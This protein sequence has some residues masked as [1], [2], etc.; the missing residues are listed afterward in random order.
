MIYE[1][2]FEPVEVITIFQNGLMQPLRFRWKGNVYK[3]SKIH[4]HWTTPQGQA[5]EHH[6]AVSAGSPDSFELV[7]NN[8]DLNWQLARVALE[9]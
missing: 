7:F 1:E 4:S 6:F 3:V 2:V 8:D 5:C 9:G